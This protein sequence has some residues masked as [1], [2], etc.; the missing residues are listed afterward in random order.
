MFEYL[1]VATQLKHSEFIQNAEERQLIKE[2]L[3]ANEPT[4]PFYYEALAG[5]GRQLTDW[6]ERLQERYDSACEMPLD[7]APFEKASK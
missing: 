6:G 4:E 7:L 5:L 1:K 2:A 3:L